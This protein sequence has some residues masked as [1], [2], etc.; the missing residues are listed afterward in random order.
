MSD[1]LRAVHGE[2][3][4]RFQAR[5]L[6]ETVAAAERLLRVAEGRDLDPELRSLVIG[7]STM[8]L[9]LKAGL[10]SDG[11]ELLVAAERMADEF[12]SD[13]APEAM[14]GA[15]T[16]L[17]VEVHLLIKAGHKDQAEAQA[18]R[19]E[20]VYR[21]RPTLLNQQAIAG[22]L[23][24]AAY[25][26]LAAQMPR[27]A[28]RLSRAVVDQVSDDSQAARV[29]AIAQVWV[30][31]TTMYSGGL[32]PGVQVLDDDALMSMNVAQL[33]EVAPV[34]AEAERLQSM[35]PEAVNA[36]DTVVKRLQSSG[37][38]D[39]ALV[40]ILGVRVETVRELDQPDELRS[41]LQQFIDTCAGIEKWHAPELIDEYRRELAEV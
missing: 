33:H 39:R 16:A 2:M 6:P 41:A 3:M 37:Q 40:T 12:A 27:L 38:W 18:G 30:V 5:E 32:A 21:E 8:W 11:D 22:Q 23:L 17:C 36:I 29:A 31:I 25:F 19:L 13:P 10:N 20:R 15:V 24:M 34:I 28:L 35:G 7:A 1:D 9:Q 4:S 14:V 26:L